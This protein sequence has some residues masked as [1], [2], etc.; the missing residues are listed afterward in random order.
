MQNA[1]NKSKPRAA[2][3]LIELLIVIA[4][5]ALLIGILLP[6]L[7]AA[8]RTAR[9]GICSNNLRQFNTAMGGF[10][11]DYKD[12][13]FSFP[14]KQGDP[15]PADM[16]NKIGANG[17]T[18]DTDLE[19]GAFNAVYYMRK[20]AG[21]NPSDT[22]VPNNWFPYI[23]YSHLA[24]TPYLGEKLPLVNN[25]CPED[26]WLLTAQKYYRNPAESGIPWD[27]STDDDGRPTGWRT[28][29]RSSYDVHFSNYGPDRD[30][31]IMTRS[32]AARVP[33][34][35]VEDGLVYSAPG[36]NFLIT[37]RGVYASKKLADVRFPS[38]KT[39]GSDDFDRHHGRGAKFYADPRA[40]QP[41]PFYDGSVRV[42]LTSE[43]NPG[44]DPHTRNQ[45]IVRRALKNTTQFYEPAYE[46]GK[47]VAYGPTGWYK[48]GR[49]GNLGWDV[50]RGP[51]RA[52]ITIAPD[53]KM[54]MERKAENELDTTV[55][56]W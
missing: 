56:T 11:K 20:F 22:P 27:T 47:T 50:P 4:I 24:L 30:R 42:L 46:G 3:T 39:W 13:L 53:G 49:G 28:V 54:T 23:R 15:L 19:A 7:G 16:G 52:G 40:R 26:S 55:G 17:F 48:Y 32:G 33:F 1:K 51:V 34:Y 45:M 18:F 2:F 38:Q 9:V 12:T 14:W 37:E 41:L 6:A 8:R 44:W 35:Y 29:F 36:T 31:V 10:A 21:L 43:T 25:A 5:I